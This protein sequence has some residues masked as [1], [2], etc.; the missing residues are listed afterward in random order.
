MGR[1]VGLGSS[2]S[3]R[4]LRR[5]VQMTFDDSRG[6]RVPIPVMTPSW[7]LHS[8]HV[9]GLMCAVLQSGWRAGW[10]EDPRRDHSVLV[11]ILSNDRRDGIVSARRGDKPVHWYDV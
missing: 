8:S 2:C 1:L 10:E 4:L 11:C 7:K 5:L 6:L 3:S 9:I